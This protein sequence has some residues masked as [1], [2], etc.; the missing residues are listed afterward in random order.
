V[1]LRCRTLILTGLGQPGNLLRAPKAHVRGFIV[2][3]APADSLAD[4]IRRVAAGHRPRTASP[5][6]T[7]PLGWPCRRRRSATTCPTPSPKTGARNRID[8]IRIARDAGWL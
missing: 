7:S 3:D 1:L 8:A 5:P 2:K 6:A 4:G